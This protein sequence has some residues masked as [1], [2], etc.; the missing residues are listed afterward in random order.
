MHSDLPANLEAA[1][2]FQRLCE[3][4]RMRMR[5]ARTWN[6]AKS[7]S[8]RKSSHFHQVSLRAFIATQLHNRLA[9][10]YSRASA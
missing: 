4:G 7:C 2:V 9:E 1:E 5:A 10:E 8:A 6:A 3:Q